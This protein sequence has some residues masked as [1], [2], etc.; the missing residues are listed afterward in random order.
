MVH[1]QFLTTLGRHRIPESEDKQK[2]KVAI[3]DHETGQKRADMGNIAATTEAS[4]EQ[5]N[6]RG[7]FVKG[8]TA[9]VGERVRSDPR[10]L[11]SRQAKG[12]HHV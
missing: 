5:P 1:R 3:R 12:M 7:S 10:Y 6:Q 9:K 2:T 4:I 11:K 8:S